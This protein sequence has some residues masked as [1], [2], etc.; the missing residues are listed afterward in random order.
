MNRPFSPIVAVT[1]G[2]LLA[3]SIAAPPAPARAQSG[4]K[5]AA[6]K[7]AAPAAV[8]VQGRIKALTRSPR[9]GS[10][11]YKDAVVALH[12]TGAKALRGGRLPGNSL[13]IYVWGMKDNKLRPAASYKPGQTITLALQPWERAEGTYGGYNRVD[14][15]D[16]DVLALPTYWGEAAPAARK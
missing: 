3:G 6:K 2:L 15:E 7:P 11:P 16:E 13:L 10:V 12:L 4:K 9:P 14:L 5:P 1:L 8:V